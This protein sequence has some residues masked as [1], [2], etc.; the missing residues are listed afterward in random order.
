VWSDL[1]RAT[2]SLI[3]PRRT[4]TRSTRQVIAQPRE[5][6][7]LPSDLIRATVSL[8]FT[9]TTLTSLTRQLIAARRSL[10]T[11]SP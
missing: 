7:T 3:A 1:I 5:L 9:L 10:I 6:I 4:L 11:I 8:I 2:F